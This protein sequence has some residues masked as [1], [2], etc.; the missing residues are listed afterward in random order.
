M[1]S[2]QFLDNFKEVEAA[3]DKWQRDNHLKEYEQG[4]TFYKAALLSLGFTRKGYDKYGS[5]VY[6]N[7]YVRVAVFYDRGDC[8]W[9][10]E[11]AQGKSDTTDDFYNTTNDEP[12]MYGYY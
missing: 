12:D 9:Y 4:K 10:M 2:T 1:K 8:C 7:G 5:N 11:E 6:S 3:V